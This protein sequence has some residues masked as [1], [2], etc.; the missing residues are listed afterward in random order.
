MTKKTHLVIGTLVSVPMLASPLG[1]LGIFG[2]IAP[3]FDLKLGKV[4]HRTF[5]HSL[6]FLLFTTMI[7][8]IFSKEIALIWFVSYTSHL[9]LDSMTRSGIPLFMPLK[10]KRYGL[11]IFLTGGIFDKGLEIIGW[12]LLVICVID[13]FFNL[14]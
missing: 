7:I 12:I 6:I 3:D 1:L 13:M 4:F 9:V 2:S 10:N 11:R 5:T 14:F 8:N